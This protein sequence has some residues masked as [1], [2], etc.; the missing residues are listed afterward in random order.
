MSFAS[1]SF[2]SSGLPGSPTNSRPNSPTY[3]R[4]SHPSTYSKPRLNPEQLVALAHDSCSPRLPLASPDP[5]GEAAH[6]ADIE[7]ANFTELPDDVFLPFVNR[8]QEVSALFAVPPCSKLLALLSQTF[9]GSLSVANT[10]PDSISD[11]VFSLD[12]KQ[13][14]AEHLAYWLKQVERDRAPD[15]I[16]VARAR[17]C[18]LEHSELI[19]QRIKGAL[20]VPPDL[21]ID[22]LVDIDDVTGGEDTSKAEF[23]AIP[24]AERPPNANIIGDLTGDA[25]NTAAADQTY[26]HDAGVDLPPSPP[27]SDIAIEH[28]FA[29]SNPSP[30]FERPPARPGTH[31][32][33]E[34]VQ[35]EDE[36]E[37][38][39]PKSTAPPRSE[40]VQGIR[41]STVPSSPD[42][43]A[44]ISPALSARSLGMSP[45]GD[46][47]S[48]LP[49]ALNSAGD[50]PIPSSSSPYSWSGRRRSSSAGSQQHYA[51]SVASSESAYDALGERGPGN[52]L[53]P[54][55]FARLT[56]RPTLSAK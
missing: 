46:S 47:L 2:A 41:I 24:L 9:A 34:A 35:E 4:G 22:E 44:T 16:W 48:S 55:S 12:P 18:V 25:S 51:S 1:T 31:V 50:A 20:G 36:S 7:P 49:A 13:W 33:P 38:A 6:P 52:P 10:E 29:D 3:F 32:L 15:D 37:D 27:P 11:A 39:E 21:D 40:I 45:L 42:L 56:L 14:N 26:A 8:A 19:W 53:F 28:I 5:S 17:R 54:S 30:M 23:I 43:F